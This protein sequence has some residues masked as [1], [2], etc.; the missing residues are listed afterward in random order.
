MT[1]LVSSAISLDDRIRLPLSFDVARMQADIQALNLSDYIYYSVLPLRSPA[2]L[3]DPTLPSPPLAE[4]YADGSWTEWLDT[5]ML[6][7]SPY[8]LSVVDTFRA[9]STVTLVRLLRLAPGGMVKEHTD[10]TLGLHIPKS[11][12]R[13][14]IPI[15]TNDNVEFF[16]NG[17][18]VPM[19]LGEC[20]YLRLTDPHQVIN[21]GT[22]DR[23]NMTIDIVP[24]DW[25]RALIESH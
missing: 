8:L 11:V 7:T 1:N 17:K 12:I 18:P 14:T 5:K 4:D 25:L 21:E 2:H 10:P 15:Q 3:V 6:K 13:L 16:L 19:Q 9:H 22:N 20:W 23:I 24:N